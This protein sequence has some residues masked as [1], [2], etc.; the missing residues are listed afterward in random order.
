MPETSRAVENMEKE[1]MFDET[2]LD[3]AASYS[4]QMALT[5]WGTRLCDTREK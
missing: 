4:H 5:E 3:L 1:P 2:S